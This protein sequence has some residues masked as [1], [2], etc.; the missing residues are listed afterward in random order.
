MKCLVLIV[1]TLSRWINYSNK[2]EDISVFR[3]ML[4]TEDSVVSIYN[5]NNNKY[6]YSAFILNNSK[7]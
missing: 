1:Q 2:Y 6:L 5:N 3:N 7:R 4:T